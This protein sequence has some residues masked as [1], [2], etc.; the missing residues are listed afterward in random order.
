MAVILRHAVVFKT[1]DHPLL[2][3]RSLHHK[4]QAE[5][6][7]LC[8]VSQQSIAAYEHGT[9]SPSRPHLLKLMEV[10][11]LPVEALVL[12][13]QFLYDNPR[14]L[15]PKPKARPTPQPRTKLG[16]RRPG[17]QG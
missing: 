8:Q 6:A 1:M 11:G 5:L 3:W 2:R 17:R 4:T 10:T 9:R 12:P 14:F 13:E 7:D 16:P 15:R